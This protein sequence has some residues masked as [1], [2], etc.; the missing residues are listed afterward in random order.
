M[1]LHSKPLICR[2]GCHDPEGVEVYLWGR[3]DTGPC[4]YVPGEQK[5]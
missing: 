2:K 4:V 1:R 3:L 5:H